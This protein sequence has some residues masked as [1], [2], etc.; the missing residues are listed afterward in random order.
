MLVDWGKRIRKGYSDFIYFVIGYILSRVGK[1]C[2]E[3]T[4]VVLERKA[5]RR[6]QVVKAE[7]ISLERKKKGQLTG[8][9]VMDLPARK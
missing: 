9:Q 7:N 2:Y 4:D 6:P 3:G 5:E 1:K 8:H